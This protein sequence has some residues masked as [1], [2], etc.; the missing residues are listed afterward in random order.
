MTCMFGKSLSA[1]LKPR[2]RLLAVGRVGGPSRTRR[3][4]LPSM[5]LNSARTGRARDG[6]AGALGIDGQ[7]FRICERSRGR[8]ES[9]RSGKRRHDTNDT[10]SILVF[11]FNTP[12]TFAD[13]SKVI[14]HAIPS[15]AGIDGKN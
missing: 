11:H 7:G 8:Q 15:V 4:P 5:A 13:L 9:N 1:S 6:V 3:L 14:T 2:N 10:V 12:G